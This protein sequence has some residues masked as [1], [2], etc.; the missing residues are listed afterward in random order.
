[1][2]ALIISLCVGLLGLTQISYG[3]AETTNLYP[4]VEE[5]VVLLE[6]TGRSPTFQQPI[7]RLEATLQAEDRE[8]TAKMPIGQILRS[9]DEQYCDVITLGLDASIELSAQSTSATHGLFGYCLHVAPGERGYPANGAAYTLTDEIVGEDTLAALEQ[10][11]QKSSAAWRS[12]PTQ[13]AV[14]ATLSGS[15]TPAELN[16]YVAPL[17]TDI[18]WTEISSYLPNPVPPTPTSVPTSTP[19][20]VPTATSTTVTESESESGSASPPDPT[21]A[22]T[23]SQSETQPGETQPE[24]TQPEE[25]QP[26]ETQPPPSTN[27]PANDVQGES[28]LSTGAGTP[29]PS[30]TQG[31][32][33]QPTWMFWAVLVVGVMIAGAI[34]MMT[35]QAVRV[36]TGRNTGHS[37]GHGAD[38]ETG[39]MEHGSS[40]PKSKPTPPRSPNRYGS[41]Q[42]LPNEQEDK[43]ELIENFGQT[44]MSN[45][46]TTQGSG[47]Q[48]PYNT[49][50][51]TETQQHD[52][53]GY[54]A[55]Q[56]A[57][58]PQDGYGN[59]A[60]GNQAYG[61]QAYRND[62]YG[63][64]AYGRSVPTQYVN[65][66]VDQMMHDG[67][68]V[69]DPTRLV[70]QGGPQTDDDDVKLTLISDSG[71]MKGQRFVVPAVGGLVS[72]ME[73][74][75]FSLAGG[76]ISNPHALILYKNNRNTNEPELYIRDLFSVNGTRVNGNQITPGADHVLKHSDVVEIGRNKLRY[77]A[78]SRSLIHQEGGNSLD[79][80]RAKIAR[81]IVG[82]GRSGDLQ[83]V[84]QPHGGNI[85]RIQAFGIPDKSISIP[86]A[87]LDISDGSII[88]RNL[89]QFTERNGE[90]L[91]KGE[92]VG[93][94]DHDQITLGSQ[95]FTVRI[96]GLEELEGS[97]VDGRY[98]IEAQ[99]KMGGMAQI[100]EV[101]DTKAEN[102][103]S[104][105]IKFANENQKKLTGAAKKSYE[106]AFVR[107]L[108]ISKQLSHTN[109]VQIDDTGHDPKYGSYLV[110]EM[111]QGKD[112]RTILR[113]RRTLSLDEAS[114]I[115]CQ[116][117][118][119]LTYMHEQGYAHCDIKPG[120]I[121]LERNRRVV[122][123][124]FGAAQ[125]LAS[126]EGPRF[127]TKAYAPTD[128]LTG[129]PI[130]ETV[131]AYM[132]AAT[133]F[134][135]LV[136]SKWVGEPESGNS[137]P[138]DSDVFDTMLTNG[139]GDNIDESGIGGEDVKTLLSDALKP[140]NRTL[141][142]WEFQFTLEKY[143]TTT[144]FEA[145]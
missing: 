70:G 42:P 122:L 126:V 129:A 137:E 71:Q 72:R 132:L 29:D 97:L 11:Q 28:T 8:I 94:R 38:Y 112:L 139:I 136:G 103:V 101:V 118:D 58:Y 18:F 7:L 90:T 51:H 2:T 85:N 116:I 100:C 89:G 44:S 41:Q 114:E 69:P 9:N 80:K 143:R 53:Y 131:D 141:E 60:Y 22:P 102:R 3:Q 95:K 20:S 145:V 142:L 98:R 50:G 92:R 43:T 52:T 56:R 91:N 134:E 87:K 31:P 115:I 74:Q 26:E 5:G 130:D 35:F 84:Y 34:L 107:E 59:Q 10:I 45:N 54:E 128:Y 65:A 61:N 104:K 133:L 119:G 46:N 106:Q 120:N 93:L 27:D 121:M 57:D 17:E 21:V 73:A 99:L 109:L 1:M 32:T 96:A 24:E 16:E 111:L 81:W 125:E 144:I 135:M 78:R 67:Q 33:G 113:E 124:D 138:D 88:L 86:H 37:A 77:D 4:L 66:P 123:I 13:L 110:M 108:K 49:N 68:V 14:W 6:V 82:S 15:T 140:A 64:N 127:S 39:T 48:P 62:A 79:L 25:T 75:I 76:D 23:T 63:E 117:V 12:L 105:V 55:T 83:F 36:D 19:T 40:M 30:S 47:G